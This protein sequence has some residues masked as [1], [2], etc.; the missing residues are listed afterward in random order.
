M[1]Y[2][3]LGSTGIGVSV[4]GFGTWGL[5]GDSYGDVDDAVSERALRVAQEAGINFFDT[6]DLYGGGHSEEVL[7]RTF[8][9]LR[10]RVVIATKG[11]TLPHR[12]FHMPQDF[13][14]SY[15]TSALEASLRRLGTDYVDLY[16]LHS[17]PIDVLEKEPG[18]VE[19]LERLRREGKIRSYGISV[20][21]PD[22]GVTAVKRWGF[23]VVQVNFNMIDQR[24]IDN[25]LFELAGSTATGIIARTPLAFGYLTGALTGAEVFGERDHRRNW[26]QDQRERWAQAPSR[27]AALNEHRDRTMAQLA[28]QYCLSHPAVSTT[29]PGMLSAAEVVEN[30]SVCGMPPLGQDE[31]GQVRCIYQRSDF[32]DRTAKAR[33]RQ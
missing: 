21:S 18:I 20:R 13:S 15:L 9:S 23:P 26:P 30:V 10:D 14:P 22:E 1:E 5:G 27:F 29:I 11:G 8:A 31:L 19:T 3:R 28:L 2:R 25:G 17:P 24:A 12:G 33:G 16:Q 6:A 32:F 7:G 4:L